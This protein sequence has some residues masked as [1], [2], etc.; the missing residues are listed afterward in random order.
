VSFSVPLLTLETLEGVVSS[1][2]VHRE[3]L[4]YALVVHAAFRLKNSSLTGYLV[5][6]LSVASIERLIRAIDEWEGRQPYRHPTR[7]PCCVR[8]ARQNDRRS[9]RVC[10]PADATYRKFIHASRIDHAS[11]A[12]QFRSIS[13]EMCQNVPRSRQSVV[14]RRKSCKLFSRGLQTSW[15]PIHPRVFVGLPGRQPELRVA[16]PPRRTG[17][18]AIGPARRH[19]LVSH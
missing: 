9:A 19:R 17:H 7:R 18:C 8:R 3:G 1:I 2:K 13:D 14:K 12:A 16:P 15:L 4:R 5:I 10:R 11:S 6:V